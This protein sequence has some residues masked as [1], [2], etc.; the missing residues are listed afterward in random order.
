MKK[1]RQTLKTYIVPTINLI[2]NLNLLSCIQIQLPEYQNSTITRSAKDWRID[3]RWVTES[4]W[5]EKNHINHRDTSIE[6][7]WYLYISSTSSSPPAAKSY[8]A[9]PNWGFSGFGPSSSWD[10]SPAKGFSNDSDLCSTEVEYDRG[11]SLTWTS[12]EM[13][14]P[15]YLYYDISWRDNVENELCWLRQSTLWYYQAA[16]KRVLIIMMTGLNILRWSH[17]KSLILNSIPCDFSQYHA[18]SSANEESKQGNLI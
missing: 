12:F 1:E 16:T 5:R 4:S 9:L 10:P 14:L 18:I 11:S 3:R 2:F 17:M 8:N 6:K 13:K 7:M 15:S